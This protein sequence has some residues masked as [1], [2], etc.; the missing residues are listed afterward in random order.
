MPSPSTLADLGPAQAFF[1]SGSD[2]SAFLHAQLASNVTALAVGAWQWSAWLDA[3][4]RVRMLCQ[5]AHCDTQRYLLVL[6]GG[7]AA[8][9][10]AALRPFVFRLQVRFDVLESCRRAVGTT[11]PMYALVKLADDNMALGLEDRS[12]II[13]AHSAPHNDTL[14][15]NFVR[16]DIRAGLPALPD[17]A[18]DT[19]LP[20]ALSLY[21][22]GAVA[23]D[24]GCYPG[25]EI[26]AR[27]HHLGGHKH[28]LCHLHTE[29][30]LQPG[31]NILTGDKAIGSVLSAIAND[32]LSVM[33]MDAA[34]GEYSARVQKIFPA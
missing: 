32:A 10:V 19:L 31:D 22:L 8:T 33:T 5:L 13:S 34:Q 21:R 6:R 2:A 7:D 11:L 27:L 17:D 4:G 30:N 9:M 25:Q 20:P 28:R 23:L 24:K 3:R 1:V 26:V 12:C 18:L 16:A 15:D 14:T 29:R